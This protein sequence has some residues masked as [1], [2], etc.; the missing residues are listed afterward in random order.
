[1]T[2]HHRFGRPA[3]LDLVGAVNLLSG[4]NSTEVVVRIGQRR[5]GTPGLLVTG[6]CFILPAA[7]MVLACAWAY[8]RYAQM[9]LFGAVRH[10]VKPVVVAVTLPHWGGTSS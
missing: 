5:A 6:I 10:G 4:P 1:V 2:R 3:V 7:V 8:R 9:R